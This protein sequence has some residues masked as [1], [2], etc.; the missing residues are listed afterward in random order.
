[1]LQYV[2]DGFAVLGALYTLFSVLG[3]VLPNGSVK[4]FFANL[5][6]DI[7]AFETKITP[8]VTSVVST[9]VSDIKKV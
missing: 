1:M 6:L 4:T 9:V 8:A 5:S 7:S 3:N 2:T